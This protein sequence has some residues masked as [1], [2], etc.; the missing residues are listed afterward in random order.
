[1]CINNPKD[2]IKFYELSKSQ[3]VFTVVQQH[4]D[5]PSK[6]D[7]LLTTSVYSQTMTEEKAQQKDQNVVCPVYKYAPKMGSCLGK[8][9]ILL[10][11]PTKID[12]KSIKIH[13]ENSCWSAQVQDFDIKDKMISFK[14]PPYTFENFSVP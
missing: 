14:S 12:K 6:F 2:M 4:S 11:L 9:D 7:A 5:N 8:D 3:L 13:F 1:M 10:F